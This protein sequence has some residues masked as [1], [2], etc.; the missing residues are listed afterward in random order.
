MNFKNTPT[1]FGVVTKL[2]HWLIGLTML[3]LVWLGWYMVDLTYF[4]KWYNQSLNYHKSAGM[5]VLGLATFWL[6][7]RMLSPSPQALESSPLWVR[8]SASIMHGVLILLMFVIPLTGYVISASAG[9]PVSFFDWFNIP[10][11]L[12]IGPE[13]RDFAIVAHYYM[14]YGLCVLVVGHAVAAFKHQFINRDGTLSRM[15]WR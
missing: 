10:A 3:A 14:A 9:K 1:S 15:L 13:S 12:E 4:D 5:L 2:L 7:W 8:R 11:L 6:G